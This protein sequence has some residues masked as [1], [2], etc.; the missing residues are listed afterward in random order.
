MAE[1]REETREDRLKKEINAPNSSRVGDD[2]GDVVVN[3]IADKKPT[4]GA[5]SSTTTA[6]DDRPLTQ[7]V[8]EAL[9]VTDHEHKQMELERTTARDDRSITE[10]I[11]DTLTGAKTE[12]KEA[13][14]PDRP[15]ASTMPPKD[16]KAAADW[17]SIRHP[18]SCGPEGTSDY[19]TRPISEL[20]PP[21]EV[22]DKADLAAVRM[23]NREKA[24]P[25]TTT[26]TTTGTAAA[27]GAAAAAGAARTTPSSGERT[28]RQ[29]AAVDTGVGHPGEVVTPPMVTP[30]VKTTPPVVTPVRTPPMKP[31]AAVDQATLEHAHDESVH[32]D[33]EQFPQINA[34]RDV[35]VPTAEGQADAA[36]IRAG[37]RRSDEAKEPRI[38]RRG[39]DYE[40]PA[41][42]SANRKG[43]A[44][45]AKDTARD[46]KAKAR[47]VKEDVDRRI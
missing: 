14:T 40:T 17:D 25:P 21:T 44:E 43:V 46:V 32:Q 36:R 11:G 2:P 31:T 7:R 6:R 15:T 8:E 12:V 39:G 1:R 3:T 34:P 27:M 47:D 4:T 41:A 5:R 38:D 37:E 23:M 22:K 35:G 10:K 28:I 13:V 20:K 16:V 42:S 19:G 9:G 18:G 45:A 26:P 24:V 29:G 30:P 33:W